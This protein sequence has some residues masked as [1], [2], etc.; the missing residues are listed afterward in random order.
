MSFWWLIPAFLAGVA[1]AKGRLPRKNWLMG[2]FSFFATV[3]VVGPL[4]D[5]STVFLTLTKIT[6]KGALALYISG[7]WVNLTH[8]AAN[9]VFLLLFGNVLLEK[10]ERVK[11]RYGMMESYDEDE[12]GV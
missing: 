3:I 4:L 11:N 6:W 8:G 7:L 10:L 2:L 12:D 9:F 5:T 1:F